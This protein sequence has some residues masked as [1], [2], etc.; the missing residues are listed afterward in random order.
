MAERYFCPNCGSTNV[1]TDT[2]GFVKRWRNADIWICDDCGY[3]GFMPK[4]NPDDFDF[5]KDE[6]PKSDKISEIEPLNR[7]QLG[8]VFFFLSI[9]L[10]AISVFI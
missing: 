6:V 4:G 10:A 5:E 2:D 3:N 1:S 8:M 9:L 7:K